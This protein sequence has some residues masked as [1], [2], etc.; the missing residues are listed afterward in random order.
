MELPKTVEALPAGSSLYEIPWF[1]IIAKALCNDARDRSELQGIAWELD[2]MSYSDL[3]EF[4]EL[5]ASESS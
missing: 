2:Q 3:C 1:G 5:V 4:Y